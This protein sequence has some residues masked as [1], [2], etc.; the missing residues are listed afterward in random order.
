[1]LEDYRPPKEKRLLRK[2]EVR[3]DGKIFWA[4][5]IGY[6]ESN[7][8]VWLTQKRF[9]WRESRR[10]ER[11][12]KTKSNESKW[13]Q[14][15]ESQK[16]S[17]LKRKKQNP[18][19]FKKINHQKNQR[20]KDSGYYRTEEYRHKR[21]ARYKINGLKGRRKQKESSEQAARRRERRKQRSLNDKN[22]VIRERLRQRIS[23]AIKIQGADKR[24]KFNESLGCSIDFLRAYIQARFKPGM[25]WENYGSVWHVDHVHPLAK[26][27]LSKRRNQLAANHFT[28]LQPMFAHE[29]IIKSDKIEQQQEFSI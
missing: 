6:K 3:N 2:G 8:E 11:Y 17:M 1:M 12:A 26:L 28:N 10:L 4:Y 22:W 5:A 18:E 24:A 29:N 23:K 9:D 27:D 13:K 19:K 20:R 25:T 16:L 15:K 21:R 7:G 14:L